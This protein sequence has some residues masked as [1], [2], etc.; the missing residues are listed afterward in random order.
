MSLDH[1]LTALIV[2]PTQPAPQQAIVA[3]ALDAP[4]ATARFALRP[5]AIGEDGRAVRH[6][7]GVRVRAV[8]GA[9]VYSVRGAARYLTPGRQVA[10][11]VECHDPDCDDVRCRDRRPGEPSVH[12]P[13]QG[14]TR[15]ERRAGAWPERAPVVPATCPTAPRDAEASA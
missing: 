12:H 10:C 11:A 14:W 4:R 3:V 6:L 15:V 8:G 2:D 5:S 7:D 13:V 9:L 1:P